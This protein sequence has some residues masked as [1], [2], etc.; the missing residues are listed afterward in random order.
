MRYNSE[1]LICK[2]SKRDFI[3]GKSYKV[4]IFNVMGNEFIVVEN[5][6][7][8]KCSFLGVKEYFYTEKEIRKMK[9][10]KI[11]NEQT[12]SNTSK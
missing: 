7:G 9:L 11:N 3:K 4:S 12:K 10:D 6:N 5:E 8:V 1:I 2:E